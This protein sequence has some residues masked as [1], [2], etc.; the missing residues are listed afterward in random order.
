MVDNIILV[1]EAIHS[2]QSRKEKGMAIKLDMENAFDR[3]RHN[4]LLA[5]LSRF[6][7]NGLFLSWIHACICSP[8]ISPLVNGRP[9]PFFQLSRGLRQG[10]PLSPILY[11]LM[12]EALNRKLDKDRENKLIPG[13]KIA[14]GVKRINN[15][16]FVD[17]TI[18]LGGAST[19]LARRFKATMDD[20]T[21]ASGGKVNELKSQIYG[22]NVPQHEMQTIARILNFTGTTTWHSFNY[23]GIPI[24]LK[25]PPPWLGTIS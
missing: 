8:W 9:T 23:L 17:D 21:T 10:C 19:I 15:S 20:Y 18:L 24:S 12:V 14:Q 25:S 2:S 5:V 3:V 4:F 7:F 1:Q 13:I 6:G 22:W 16:Q 11:I